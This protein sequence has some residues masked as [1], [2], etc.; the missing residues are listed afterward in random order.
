M[1]LKKK[2]HCHYNTPYGELMIGVFTHSIVNELNESGGS[3]YLKYTIDIN[4]S[5]VSDNE[6]LMMVNSIKPKNNIIK[7]NGIEL[8]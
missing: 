6:I 3:L 4:S 1:I 8:K 2:Q 7:N 5:Y